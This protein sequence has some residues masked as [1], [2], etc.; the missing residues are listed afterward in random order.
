MFPDNFCFHNK[1]IYYFLVIM[2]LFLLLSALY[3]LFKWN[4]I[5]IHAIQKKKNIEEVRNEN[6]KIIAYDVLL[7]FALHVIYYVILWLLFLFSLH[8]PGPSTKIISRAEFCINFQIG[9]KTGL[10]LTK[11]IF[12]SSCYRNN[13]Y[14]KWIAISTKINLS[15]C[16]N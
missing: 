9:W 16:K 5:R 2:L 4:M 3:L 7:E 15:K 1:N 10:V 6:K 12:D 13:C 8:W 11:S 14:E